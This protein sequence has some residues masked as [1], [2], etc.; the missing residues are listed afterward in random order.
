MVRSYERHEP[1]A[2]FAL[3]CSNAANGVLETD[4]KTAVLPAL[5]DVL[6]WDVKRGEQVRAPPCSHS[7]SVPCGTRLATAAP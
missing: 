6:V 7:H 2:A 1:T 3:V 4:G 5:E